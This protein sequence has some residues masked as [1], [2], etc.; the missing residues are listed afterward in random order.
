MVR[1]SGPTVIYVTGDCSLSGGSLANLTFLPK[2]LQWYPMG[3]KC[4]ISGDSA[5][6]GAVYGPTAKIERSGESD[7][8]G[9]IIGGELVLSGSGGIHADESLDSQSLEGGPRNAMLVQ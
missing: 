4:A 7:Y 8:Y 6:Y 3:S 5:F 2:N 1:I 9:S